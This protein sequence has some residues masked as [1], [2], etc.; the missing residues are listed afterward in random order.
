[1]NDVR[2]TNMAPG[3]M[4]L[5]TVKLIELLRGGKDGEVKTDDEL[6]EHC[7]YN[8]AV[9]KPGYGYLQSAIRYCLREHS[10]VWRRRRNENDIQCLNDS[11]KVGLATQEKQA[12]RRRGKRSLRVLNTVDPAK[13][14]DEGRTTHWVEVATVGTLLS[15]TAPATAKKLAQQSKAEPLDA[16]GYLEAMRPSA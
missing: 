8:T 4:R 6:T 13:L 1:M 9:G 16:K 10:V 7:G 15:V 12:I 5:A 2:P 11:Q 14:D 3:P